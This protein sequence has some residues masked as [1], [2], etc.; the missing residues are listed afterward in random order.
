MLC[1]YKKFDNEKERYKLEK[2]H[3][4]DLKERHIEFI[5]EKNAIQL[6]KLKNRDVINENIIK[7]N[8]KFEKNTN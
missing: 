4:K 1:R 7:H 2:E 3:E 8:L 5:K 6:D